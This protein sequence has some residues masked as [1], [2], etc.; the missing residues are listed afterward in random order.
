MTPAPV[1]GLVVD[2]IRKIES[3]CMDGPSIDRDPRAST[4]TCS[5]RA[6]RAT[7]PGIFPG[8]TWL[9]ATWAK[10]SRPSGESGSGT[11]LLSWRP[12]RRRDTVLTAGRRQ[13][14]RVPVPRAT[15]VPT[16]GPMS[17]RQGHR[18]ARQS[19]QDDVVLVAQTLLPGALDARRPAEQLR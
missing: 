5:P 16:S 11:R 17:G 8:P 18:E 4:W 7:S 19:A 14:H 9:A 1:T 6:T 3:L 15:V 2:A 13:S 10:R 12:P